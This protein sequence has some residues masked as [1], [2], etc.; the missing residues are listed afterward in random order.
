MP[1]VGCILV[2]RQQQVSDLTLYFGVIPG[3]IVLL[4]IYGLSF[5]TYRLSQRAVSP[6][7]SLAER[8]EAYDP[9]RDVNAR[10]D[11]DDLRTT[12]TPRL[13]R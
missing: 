9:T 11:L 7:V 8:L 1:R 4:F 10:L 2:F 6:L 3:A 13:P 12:P 5:V